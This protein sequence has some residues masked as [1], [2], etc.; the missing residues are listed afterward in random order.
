MGDLPA[1]QH[2]PVISRRLFVK[3]AT[4]GAGL[5]LPS[6]GT[7][8]PA[9]GALP[10][11]VVGGYWPAWPA[12]AI[13]VRDLPAAYTVVHLFAAAPSGASGTVA[14]PAAGDGRGAR[15]HLVAD[16]REARSVQRRSVLLTVGGA[17]AGIAF[18]A[19]AISTRFVDS[20]RRI[21][22]G[23]LGGVDGLDLNTFESG[24]VPDLDEYAWIV[25]RLRS[26]YGPGFAIT[27]PPAPWRDED[28]AFCRDL[29]GAGLLD[30]CS[31]QYYDGP[32][33]AEERFVVESVREWAAL[34]GPHRLGVGF[35]LVSESGDQMSPAR[36]ATTWHHVWAAVPGIRGAFAWNVAA[37]EATGWAFARDVGPLVAG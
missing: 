2:V 13:R 12:E 19:R 1:R 31:P 10:A 14:W 5:V 15:T 34:V 22:D 37:D 29:A 3:A 6:S 21:I 36:C 18:T 7:S 17:G 20:V 28:K 35:G 11:R 24:I 25:G 27:A 33:L 8:V 26:T 30:L 4:L 9:V 16:I 32:G 23:D